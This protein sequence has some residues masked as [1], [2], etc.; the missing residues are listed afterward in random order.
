M[1]KKNSIPKYIIFLSTDG[2][3]THILRGLVTGLSEKGVSVNVDH[4][5]FWS[6]AL[7]ALKAPA[8]YNFDKEKV[9]TNIKFFRDLCRRYGVLEIPK[10]LTKEDIYSIFE[11][12]NKTQGIVL[13]FSRDFTTT[14]STQNNDYYNWDQS[15]VNDLQSL[16]LDYASRDDSIIEL[17]FIALV[18]SPLDHIASLYERFSKNNSLDYF[19]NRVITNL[20]NIDEFQKKLTAL[21]MKRSNY[22]FFTL[23]GFVSNKTEV[24]HNISKLINYNLDSNFY[25]SN[26]SINKWYSCSKIYG[27][28]HDKELLEL[29]SI[30][31]YRYHLPPFFLWPFLYFWGY[32]KRQYYEFEKDLNTYLRNVDHRNPI[33][34]KHKG[35]YNQLSK[36]IFTVLRF[37]NRSNDN[38][39]KQPKF[40][41]QAMDS[42][43]NEREAK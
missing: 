43:R 28:F 3:G 23:E 5:C 37:I 25:V 9:N 15:D 14:L 36:T 39:R 6:I 27:F 18:R 24:I 31:G 33:N 13:D 26:I 22:L 40:Y 34:A 1:V 30:F 2:A 41:Y 12:I 17:K 38:L 29:A 21:T 11:E 42:V 32:V 7:C 19:R 4:Y 10:S 16:V 20:K 35:K 8:D